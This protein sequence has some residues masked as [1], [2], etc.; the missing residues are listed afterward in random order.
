MKEPEERLKMITQQFN[1]TAYKEDPASKK[2]VEPGYHLIFEDLSK[3]VNTLDQLTS[4]KPSL[5]PVDL[6]M[7][8]KLGPDNALNYPIFHL[9]FGDSEIFMD[10]IQFIL[11]YLWI[12]GGTNQKDKRW[13]SK[14]IVM[15]VNSLFG[16]PVGAINLTQL[17]LTENQL[18]QEITAI[19]QLTLVE[20]DNNDDL[21]QNQADQ[22]GAKKTTENNG[23]GGSSPMVDENNNQNTEMQ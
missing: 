5:P 19:D 21:N 23:S 8:P 16:M 3:Y 11:Q 13:A 17:V 22:K 1:I 6:K 10:T 20:L 2:K 4:I 9:W 18:K 14:M 12:M 15:L 7:V